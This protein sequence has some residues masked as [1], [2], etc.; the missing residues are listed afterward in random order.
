MLNED[1]K[2]KVQSSVEAMLVEALP[3]ITEKPEAYH[4][5]EYKNSITGEPEGGCVEFR[6]MDANHKVNFDN[7]GELDG[8]IVTDA[9]ES[10]TK[11]A[12]GSPDEAAEDMGAAADVNDVK[13][14][15]EVLK[16]LTMED[17]EKMVDDKLSTFKSA[18]VEEM[19]SYNSG[20]GEDKVKSA[21]KQEPQDESSNGGTTETPADGQTPKQPE[22]PQET[23]A[24]DQ[25]AAPSNQETNEG[26]NKEK[27]LV[28]S[29]NHWGLNQADLAKY[30]PSFNSK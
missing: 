7:D 5:V 12:E 16:A 20:M 30:F 24:D 15:E 10:A 14:D 11:A 29:S 4:F 3:E 13:P 22:T 8:E 18:L 17:V 21:E 1:I 6:F 26:E 25:S 2:T 19:K 9:S 23:P 27:S 28:D